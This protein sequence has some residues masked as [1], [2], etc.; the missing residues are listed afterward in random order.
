MNR[1]LTAALASLSI[2]C[3]T[4]ASNTG[5]DASLARR[6]A[7]AR[8]DAQASSNDG[9]ADT[10][11]GDASFPTD[12]AAP[13]SLHA[14]LVMVVQT[15][16]FS[17]IGAAFGDFEPRALLAAG[18]YASCTST[19]VGDCT[20]S[21]C[22]GSSVYE[23]AVDPG[24][25]SLARNGSVIAQLTHSTANYSTTTSEVFLPGDQ[26]RLSA[27]GDVVPAFDVSETWPRA[28]SLTIPQTVSRASGVTLTWGSE[29]DG[30]E[31]VGLVLGATY[32]HQLS[33]DAPA[34]AH[35]LTIPASA[36]A[37]VPD[38]LPATVYSERSEH[39]V[40]GD[41]GVLAL[42]REL[43]APVTITVTP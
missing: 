15:P 7:G 39:V 26:V 43:G 18:R 14:G 27:P 13:S 36:L 4:Q 41:Y 10:G 29:L 8:E 34:S 11:G 1:T 20:L 19:R 17:G 35:A 32:L 2:G 21:E 38:S 3:A 42:V 5:G 16:T 31:R 40:V 30:V 37:G 23:T 9:G 28:A 25:I 24:V 6:D 22:S 33:C 12:G